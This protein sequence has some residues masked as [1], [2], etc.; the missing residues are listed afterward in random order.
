MAIIPTPDTV[1]GTLTS[2][3]AWIGSVTLTG[4]VTIPS[5]KTLTITPGATVT[6]NSGVKLIVNGGGT[7]I[8][9]GATFQGN[10]SAGSWNSIWFASNGHGTIQSCTIRD[11]QCG[12]YTIREM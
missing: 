6:F 12:I 4:N 1:S 10:G 3:E 9:N 11:A 5:G 2:N 7:L 8:A